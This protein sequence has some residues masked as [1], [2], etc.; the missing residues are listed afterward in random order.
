MQDVK[1]V[2]WH[3][4]GRILVS[5]SYDDTIKLWRESDD[6]WICEQTLSGVCHVLCTSHRT[7]SFHLHYM[8]FIRQSHT[9]AATFSRFVG[10]RL[11]KARGS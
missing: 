4:K 8:P 7:P 6:E 2:A 3:P 10:V 1:A 5:C 9:M 11:H